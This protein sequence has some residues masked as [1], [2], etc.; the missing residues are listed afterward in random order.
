MP[1]EESLRALDAHYQAMP[2]VAAMQLRIAGYDGECLRLHAPL[3]LHV[4]D[5]GCAFG[6]S[7]VSLMTLSSWGL[8]SLRIREAGLRAD[9]YVADSS[10]RYLAPLYADLLSESRL[11]ADASWDGFISTLRER[12]RARAGLAARIPLPDGGTA[13]EAR[14][15][16]VAIATR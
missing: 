8:V 9:V 11:D 4:N 16:Y 7:M 10:V 13:A 5:K 14:A 3:A 15:R 1:L 12:G 6:G 2:P